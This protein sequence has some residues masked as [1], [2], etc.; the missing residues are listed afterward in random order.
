[1]EDAHEPTECYRRFTRGPEVLEVDRDYA[2]VLRRENGGEWAEEECAWE[3]EAEERIDEWVEEALGQ[4][5]EEDE[6]SRTTVAQALTERFGELPAVYQAFLDAGKHEVDGG[7]VVR[8]MPMFAADHRVVV[9]LDNVRIV[10]MDFCGQ[11]AGQRYIPISTEM[12]DE[13]NLDGDPHGLFFAI[14]R[15]S[16]VGAVAMVSAG[17]IT[18]AY[19]SFDAFV[20]AMG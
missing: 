14:D 16:P 20:G 4:G 5:W 15:E 12:K 10:W 1:M 7:V 11:N 3:G 9:E 13:G 8:G 19:E 17:A 2:R 6:S 18:P